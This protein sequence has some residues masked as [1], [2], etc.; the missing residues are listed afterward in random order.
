MEIKQG[1]RKSFDIEFVLV[2][3]SNL[4]EV[5]TW[6][7][8]AVGGKGKDRFIRL[9]DKGAQNP[10]QKKAFI[11]DFIV[12][13]LDLDTYKK[14]SRKAFNASYEETEE[15]EQSRSSISGEYVSHAEAAA[16]PETTVTETV[17]VGLTETEKEADKN[18]AL[19][20][21]AGLG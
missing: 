3:E 10:L 21:D 16:N 11:G 13:H 19:P 1:R 5:A 17:E 15:R 2:T 9:D 7:S 20:R 14:F 12:R 4:Q 8:A 18:A 6:A